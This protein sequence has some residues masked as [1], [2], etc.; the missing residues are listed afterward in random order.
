MFFILFFSFLP[1]RDYISVCFFHCFCAASTKLP[2]KILL[3]FTI[4]LFIKLGRDS[5]CKETPN[6]HTTTT[7]FDV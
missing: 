5:F 1:F 2:T 6:H 3:K 7:K 4:Y